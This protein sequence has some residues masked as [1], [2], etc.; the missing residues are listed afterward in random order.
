MNDLTFP[1]Q[2][3]STMRTHLDDQTVM[4]LWELLM[5]LEGRAERE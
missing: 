2:R 4:A 1:G 3:H 5:W